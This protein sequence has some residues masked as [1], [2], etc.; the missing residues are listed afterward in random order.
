M[1]IKDRY[2]NLFRDKQSSSKTKKEAKNEDSSRAKQEI[3]LIK[4]SINSKLKDPEMAKKAAQIITELLE[5]EAQKKKT[6]S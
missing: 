6:G 2:K 5:Q 3:D 4:K 1:P